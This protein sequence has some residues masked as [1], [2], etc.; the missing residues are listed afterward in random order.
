[1]KR[2]IKELTHNISVKR[3][4]EVKWE[5]T[6]EMQGSETSVKLDKKLTGISTQSVLC[7]LGE[8]ERTIISMIIHDCNDHRI[9]YTSVMPG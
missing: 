8:S 6:S 5:N 7:L 4:I 9:T 3:G 1:M 2:T